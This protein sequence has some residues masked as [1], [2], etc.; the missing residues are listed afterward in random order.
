LFFRQ[1]KYYIFT[2]NENSRASG[3]SRQQS[4][5]PKNNRPF[6]FFHNFDAKA[7][8]HGESEHQQNV[9][10]NHEDVATDAQ[11]AGHWF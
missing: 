5:Q 11:I 2:H 1:I 7:N 10:A 8:G 6:I 3:T 9:G 4:A